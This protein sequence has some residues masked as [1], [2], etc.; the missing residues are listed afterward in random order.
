[1][2]TSSEVMSMIYPNGGYVAVGEDF[3][4]IQFLECPP[5]TKTA[6]NKAASEY[7]AWK[8]KIKTDKEVAKAALL[9]KMGITA[10]EAKLLFS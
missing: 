2:A 9:A 8:L 4:G 1:M 3:E 6:Y 10:E 5:I 7:D